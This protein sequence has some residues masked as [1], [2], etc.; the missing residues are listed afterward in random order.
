MTDLLFCTK[1]NQIHAKL[2]IY[3][4]LDINRIAFLVAATV[5]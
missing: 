3:A 5:Y 1:Q 4:F 2:N